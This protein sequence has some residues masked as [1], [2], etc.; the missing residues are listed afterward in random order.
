MKVAVFAFTNDSPTLDTGV[1]TYNR[2][3]LIQLCRRFPQHVFTVYLATGNSSKFADIEFAN[4]AKIIVPPEQEVHSRSAISRVASLLRLLVNE[5]LHRARVRRFDFARPF[6]ERFPRLEQ[7]DLIIYTVF[8]YLPDFPLFVGRALRKK[9]IAVIHDIRLLYARAAGYA[10]FLVQQRARYL[11]SRTIEECSA[12]LVPSS[13]IRDFLLARHEARAESIFVSFI[14]PNLGTVTPQATGPRV[15]E[16]VEGQP[17]I[18][19]PSTIVDTKN[20]IGL[21]RAMAVLRDRVPDLKLVLAGS[22]TDSALWRYLERFIEEN[23]LRTRVM[24]MGFVS[25]SEKEQLYDSAIALV[26]P[27]IGESFSLPIWEAFARGCPVIASTD[28]DIPE[29]AGDAALLCNP[30]DEHDIA[31]QIQRLCSD[32]SLRNEL[33]IRGRARY[34]FVRGHSL[35]SGWETR[36]SSMSG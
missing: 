9:C 8:G 23:G 33:Q 6:F 12:V 7:H 17:F 22:N 1:T 27:S 18:F 25:E 30:Y 16:A 19:Y 15:R 28:R 26:V 3:L 13:Y 32:V 34:D 21:L 14:V 5:S 24:H 35:F 4:L 11:L 2:E 20:H 31:T 36:L 29:Q 10:D